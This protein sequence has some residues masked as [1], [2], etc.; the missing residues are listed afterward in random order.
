MISA[1]NRRRLERALARRRPRGGRGRVVALCYHSVSADGPRAIPPDVFAEHVAWIASRCDVVPFAEI[2]GGPR[3]RDRP[4]VAI[5]FDDGYRDNHA[6]ALPVLA[7]AGVTATFFLTTGLLDGD[8]TARARLGRVWGVPGDDLEAITWTQASELSDAGMH[9]GAHT[10]TH[11]NL[12]S[13]ADDQA[14]EEIVGPKRE[15]EDRLGRPVVAFAYPFGDARFDFTPATV[16]AVRDAGFDAGG[17]IQFRGI[18]P[19]DDAMTLPRFPVVNRSTEVLAAMVDGRL[20]VLGHARD[21]APGWVS[22]L[23]STGARR[24]DDAG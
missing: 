15:L 6:N 8:A 3:S 18:R 12:A 20:D 17:T 14:R 21:L 19:R 24:R 16:H 22:R 4:T 13:L 2:G 5:T 23:V 10:R 1:A 11:P 9:V 7:D